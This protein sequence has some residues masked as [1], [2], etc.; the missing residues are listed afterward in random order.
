MTNKQCKSGRRHGGEPF[1]TPPPRSISIRDGDRD[2]PFDDLF[3]GMDYNLPE[4]EVSDT[5]MLFDDMW[6]D[7]DY[8]LPKAEPLTMHRGVEGRSE[9]V[10]QQNSHHQEELVNPREES[11]VLEEQRREPDNEPDKTKGDFRKLK[12]ALSAM[13]TR[14]QRQLESDA[15]QQ[16]EAGAA[17]RQ[18]LENIREQLNKDGR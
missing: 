2:R 16:K 7:A 11:T 1:H 5:R 14:L 9:S 17:F 12:N 15:V 3:A 13:I 18:K 6:D 10:G 8:N 4:A